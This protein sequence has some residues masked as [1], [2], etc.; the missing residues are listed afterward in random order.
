MMLIRLPPLVIVL[1]NVYPTYNTRDSAV[2]STEPEGKKRQTS[3]FLVFVRC[4]HC[5]DV[6][7]CSFYVRS[8]PALI[9]ELT[10]GRKN[11]C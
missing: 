8:A 5:E 9:T 6:Q 2:L 7:Y 4:L 11:S 10:F 1:Y 3:L